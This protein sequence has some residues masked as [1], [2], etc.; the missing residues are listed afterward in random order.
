MHPFAA[1]PESSVKILRDIIDA[2]VQISGSLNSHAS[3]PLSNLKLLSLFRQQTNIS[4]TVHD[5][6][7]NI[8][9]I[10]CTLTRII[11]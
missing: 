11:R 4:H 1:D 9:L 7:K 8:S 3:L 6:R 10:I 2:T 5:V